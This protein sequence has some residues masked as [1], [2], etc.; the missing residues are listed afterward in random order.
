M[1]N[2][3]ENDNKQRIE[4]NFWGL[5]IKEILLVPAVHSQKVDEI[6]IL[7]EKLARQDEIHSILTLC[8]VEIYGGE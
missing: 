6:T 8:E 2:L 4:N 5:Q 7:V 1:F 3:T